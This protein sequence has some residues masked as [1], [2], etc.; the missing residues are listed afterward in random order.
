M[1]INPARWD[2]RQRIGA[3]VLLIVLAV[4]TKV[5]SVDGDFSNSAREAVFAVLFVALIAN[6]LLLLVATLSGF[7]RKEP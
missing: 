4:L 3:S 7:W 1:R 6:I 2:R 5:A